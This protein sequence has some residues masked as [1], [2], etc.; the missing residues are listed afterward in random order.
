MTVAARAAAALVLALALALAVAAP[1]AA[2]GPTLV[3]AQLAPFS[4]PDQ[5]GETR[6]VDASVRL[7]VLSR[8]MDGGSVVREAL[9]KQGGGAAAFLA[10]HGA[11][12][13]ADVSRMP[14]LVRSLIALPRMRSRPYPVLLDEDG[15]ATAA[16]PSEEGRATV[17]WLDALHPQRVDFAATPE[18]LLEQ[19]AL[20]APP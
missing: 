18:A 9:A 12:Y 16:L 19:L 6:A 13:V 1:A 14:G 3:P 5:H 10:A 2:G 20:P 17:L 4:L 15:K 8:D 11:V 7:V